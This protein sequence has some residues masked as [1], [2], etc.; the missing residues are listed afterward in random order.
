M[1]AVRLHDYGEP[2]QMRLEDAPVPDCLRNDVLV[3][4]VAAGV[5]PV[6][7]KLRSGAMAKGIGKTFPFVPG[8]DGA[9]VVA[10]TGSNSSGFAVGDEVFFYA[11]FARGGSY[12]EYVAVDTSQVARKPRTLCF[13][14][15]A[16]LPTPG[17][18]PGPRWLKRPRSLPTCGY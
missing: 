11:E 12:A 9:G 2:E 4:V 17:R 7:W 13:A 3:R 18:R 16:A 5:N 6:D 8:Q 15:A 10:A 14:A 1:K